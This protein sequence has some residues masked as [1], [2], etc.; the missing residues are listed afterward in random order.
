MT[1]EF[2]LRPLFSPFQYSYIQRH[3]LQPA[4]LRQQCSSHRCVPTHKSLGIYMFAGTCL[5]L[6]GTTSGEVL[7]KAM[8]C[9]VK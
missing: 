6:V 3:V 1:E 4:A 5:A 2:C 9:R 8:P 7:V